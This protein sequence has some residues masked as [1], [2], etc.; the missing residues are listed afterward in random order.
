M[1]DAQKTI[2]LAKAKALG[3]TDEEIATIVEKREAKAFEGAKSTLE[4]C[5]ELKALKA[6]VKGFGHAVRVVVEITKNT[7]GK[8]ASDPTVRVTYPTK[9]KSTTGNGNGKGK[10][11]TVDGKVYDSCQ[12]ACDAL[13]LDTRNDSA[14][15][16]LDRALKAG[17]I[18]SFGLNE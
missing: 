12:K 7:E 15:R 13:K 9:A 16:V 1:A 11:C 5:A 8:L 3:F 4:N 2:D 17:K 6:T 10:P 18:K 14:K